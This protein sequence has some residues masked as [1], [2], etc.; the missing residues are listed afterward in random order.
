MLIATA[1]SLRL[2]DQM[3][4]Y[5]MNLPKEQVEVVKQARLRREEQQRIRREA[6]EEAEEGA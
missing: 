3:D 1:Y 4:K 2:G 6:D 5:H